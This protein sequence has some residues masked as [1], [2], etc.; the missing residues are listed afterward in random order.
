[1]TTS[2]GAEHVVVRVRDGGPGIP[3]AELQSVFRPF[4]RLENS[5]SRDT[6]GTGIGLTI[7]R[8]IAEKHGGT[9]YLK[10]HI[11]GGLE[12]VLELP[13]II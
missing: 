11:E 13:L 5:R 9:L 3:E 2:R 7:A 10:N 8:N 12:A 4:F 1:V 6:G